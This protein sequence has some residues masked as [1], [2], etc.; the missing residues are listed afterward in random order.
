MTKNVKGFTF[1]ELVVAVL[2]L[3]ILAITVT[4]AV[5]RYVEK[6]RVNNT[7]TLIQGMGAALQDYK[8]TVGHYPKNLNALITNVEKEQNWEG[9]YIEKR[10]NIPMDSWG[11][12]F[13]Y[14]L[15]QKTNEYILYSWGSKGQAASKEEWIEE[16]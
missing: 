13:Q 4:P 2:I 6:A 15:D 1:I 5:M 9:P 7:K 8:L 14:K 10:K 3:G 16:E 12:P 11:N